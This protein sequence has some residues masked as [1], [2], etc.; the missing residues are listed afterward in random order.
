MDRTAYFGYRYPLVMEFN[1]KNLRKDAQRIDTF[2]KNPY[3]RIFWLS[4]EYKHMV[5][6]STGSYSSFLLGGEK[7]Q[8]DQIVVYPGHKQKDVLIDVC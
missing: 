2:I 6:A 5:F 4:P 1:G 3:E 8:K 7:V